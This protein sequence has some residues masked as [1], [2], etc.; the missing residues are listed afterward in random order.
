MYGW[1]SEC[2]TCTMLCS[3]S[4]GTWNEM[5]PQDQYVL[6]VYADDLSFSIILILIFSLALCVHIGVALVNFTMTEIER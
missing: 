3:Y 1:H 5:L 6:N 2:D 4:M